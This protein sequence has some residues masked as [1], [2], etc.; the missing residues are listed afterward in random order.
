MRDNLIRIFDLSLADTTKLC[1][2]IPADAFTTIANGKNPAWIV[3]HHAVAADMACELCGGA[4]RL[5]N[6]NPLFA[7]GS[8]PNADA[9]IHP[10]KAE[11]LDALAERHATTVTAFKAAS[12]THLAAE[13]PIPE[14]REFFPTIGDGVIYLMAAHEG[15]HN[16]QLQQW[17]LASGV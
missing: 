9:A 16:G 5:G 17:K 14:Y 10:T 15:Y 4:A 11:L 1:E 6:W 7:P 3:G 8:Q 12:D 2:N 13:F